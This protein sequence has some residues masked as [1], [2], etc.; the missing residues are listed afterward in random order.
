[1]GKIKACHGCFSAMDEEDIRCCKCGWKQGL[2]FTKKYRW[3]LGE[4]LEK[5]YLIGNVYYESGIDGITV[6]YLYDNLLSLPCFALTKNSNTPEEYL[7][8]AK[9]LQFSLEADQRF[10]VVMSVKKL[11]GEYALLFSMKDRHREIEEFESLLRS[12]PVE[13]E[14]KK[15]EKGW[16][17]RE[18][19]LKQGTVLSERYNVEDCIGVGGFGIT[20]LCEDIFLKRQVAVKEYYPAEWSER[21]DNYVAVKQAKMLPAYKF[22]MNSFVKEISISAKLLHT[23]NFPAVY[24]A[25]E[26]NDTIYMVMEY[27]DGISVGRMMKI[28]EYKPLEPEVVS[29]IILCVLE[30]LENIHD[31]Q[32][33]HSDISPGNILY[34]QQGM[35]Y[36]ID[37]GA[38]KYTLDT[39]PTLDAIFLKIEYAAPEQYRTAVEKKPSGEGPWTDIY[40]LG[41]TAYYMLTGKKPVDVIRR[42]G[43]EEMDFYSEIPNGW[44]DIIKHSME[45]EPVKRIQSVS[46]L[47]EKIK[48]IM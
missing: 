17:E 30:V 10:L 35:V 7:D 37:M 45:L 18:K 29:E 16:I 46:E 31:S 42:L 11:K 13:K 22:G 9:R 1:M 3:Q 33:V 2:A 47:K 36:L 39:Q 26:A 44:S 23:K 20:Y 8:I 21:E 34:T 43:G 4:V 28:R 25:F 19:I 40:A 15:T 24:D 12:E 38:A 14:N 6:F 32:L 5:R 48:G 41:A 27:I